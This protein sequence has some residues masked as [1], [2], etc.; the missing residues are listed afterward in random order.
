MCTVQ[1]IP[2]VIPTAELQR[3]S[4][5]AT[6]GALGYVLA[7]VAAW[8]WLHGDLTE[9]ADALFTVQVGPWLVYALIGGALVGAA[10][11]VG[12]ARYGLVAPALVVALLF[13]V[14]TY[15]TWQALQGPPVALPGTPYDLLL[16]G[17]PAVLALIAAVGAIERLVRARVLTES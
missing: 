3:T 17:W 4:R 13:A 11:A 1:A 15:R 8:G 12:A 7:L 5:A 2:D 16:V 6:A 9:L 10:V 14:A